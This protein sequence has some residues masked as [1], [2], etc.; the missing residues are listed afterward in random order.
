MSSHLTI[1][2]IAKFYG[3]PAWKIRRAVDALEVEIP[4]AGRY[5]LIP[6]EHLGALAVQLGQRSGC[7]AIRE[8]RCKT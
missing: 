8:A 4:R 2:E 3:L 5:R 6:R 1:G 7:P